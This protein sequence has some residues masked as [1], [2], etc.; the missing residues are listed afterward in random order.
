[1]KLLLFL[2]TIPALAAPITF[3]T[4]VGF[5]SNT[6]LA[7]DSITMGGIELTA[8][9][10]TRTIDPTTLTLSNLVQFAGINN[11]GPGPGTFLVP[12]HL[13]ITE[14]AP[15][16]AQSQNVG[17]GVLAGTVSDTNGVL[18]LTFSSPTVLTFT[19]GGFATT[20]GLIFDNTA[21]DQF[22]LPV[23]GQSRDL[24]ALIVQ[25]ETPEPAAFG[26]VLIGLGLLMRRRVR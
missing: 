14:T 26:L 7:T 9:N 15:P 2:L 13:T 10:V 3:T 19:N 8:T 11:P 6:G 20:F 5:G 12:F 21:L 24:A 4:S 18:R 1:M 17:S 23:P 25:T 16:P 22:N